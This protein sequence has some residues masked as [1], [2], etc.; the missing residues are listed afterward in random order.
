MTAPELPATTAITNLLARYAELIDGGKFDEIGELFAHATVTTDQGGT[1]SG[2]AG[3]QSMY[4]TTTRKH[5]DGTPRTKHV[6]TNP[7]VELDSA[8][9]GRCRSYFTVFMS[10]PTLPLQPIVAGRYRDEFRRIDGVW[11]YVRRHMIVE[12]VGDVSE[13]LSMDL[14]R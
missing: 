11:C 7:I 4:D 2:A 1:W 9:E 10:T 6:I 12:F 8:D 5:E 14:T 13:H 3:I